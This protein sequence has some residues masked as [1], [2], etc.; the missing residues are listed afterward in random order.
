M[1]EFITPD[2]HRAEVSELQ[3]E[4]YRLNTIIEQKDAQL[5]TKNKELMKNS[6]ADKSNPFDNPTDYSGYCGSYAKIQP[7]LGEVGYKIPIIL[8]NI[9]FK[10]LKRQYSIGGWC[11]IFQFLLSF[12]LPF[13]LFNGIELA[14][15]LIN[16]SDFPAYDYM[17]GSSILIAINM[18]VF[19]I[20]NILGTFLGLKWAGLK[21]T[22]MIKTRD[23][24]FG[25]ALQYCIISVFLWCLSAYSAQFIEIIFN[26][27]G[28]TCLVEQ[29]GLGETPMGMA[30]QY[31]YACIIA[32]VTE[33]MLFRGMLLK[34][35]S[36]ADQRFG[37]FATALFFGLAHG[38]IPQFI[39][40][41]SL[42]I[43]LAHITLKH[44]SI[45][46]AI[47][48]HIFVNSLSSIWGLIG[49]K[50]DE[51]QYISTMICFML[52]L[53]GL[54]LLAVFRSDGNRLPAPTPQQHRRGRVIATSSLPFLMALV[55]QISS[56]IYSIVLD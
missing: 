36:R 23:F 29:E 20:C 22:S 48:V 46:P 53:L 42:G 56:M 25:K 52:A 2:S 44:N 30:I 6:T 7:R 43:F 33:E 3:Q 47:V 34:V 54:I 35:F 55:I 49:E 17:Y 26:Q 37:I 21:G 24:T 40:A 27:F 28:K 51:W 4:I 11:I 45:V 14:L 1:D 19:L 13:L 39:L 9:E 32:P 12:I 38:N 8:D 5:Y 16:G 18:I 31:L 15:Q 41:F 50:G 10:N